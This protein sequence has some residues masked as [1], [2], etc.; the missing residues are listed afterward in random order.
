MLE[1][2]VKGHWT[3]AAQGCETT[4]AGTPDTAGIVSDIGAAQIL[5][6]TIEPGQYQVGYCI[7][8]GD[9]AYECWYTTALTRGSSNSLRVEKDVIINS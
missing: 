9:K 3:L 5:L 2:E 7:Y 8:N 6:H 4:K 1:T